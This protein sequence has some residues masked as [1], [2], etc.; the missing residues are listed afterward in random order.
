MSETKGEVRLPLYLTDTG[1]RRAKKHGYHGPCLECPLPQCIED[2]PGIVVKMFNHI[3]D[4]EIRHRYFTGE[5]VSTIAKVCGVSHK[6][7]YRVLSTP[8]L[9]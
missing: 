7:I 4:G 6:T 8:P 5:P 9:F 3:R 1:C 2:N